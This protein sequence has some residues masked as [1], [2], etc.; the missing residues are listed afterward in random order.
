[1]KFLLKSLTIIMLCII[2]FTG[3][4]DSNGEGKNTVY[5][6]ENEHSEAEHSNVIKIS[7]ASMKEIGLYTETVTLKPFTGFIKIPAKVI[8]NQ[9]NEAQVGSLVQ[10]RVHKVFVKAGDYV[11]AGQQ[12]MQVEGLEIGVIKAGYLSAKA[13]FEFQK[14]NYNRQKTLI[15]QNIGSQKSLLEAKAEFEKSLAEY[16]AEDKKIHSVGLT[17]EDINIGEHDAQH[18]SGTLSVKSPISGIVVERNVV[19]GQLVDGTT[20]AFRIVNINSVWIDGQ[21]YEKDISKL[22]TKTNVVFTS[23]SYDEEKFTGRID[24]IGQIIDEKS[25]TIS[26]RA[27]FNNPNGKLKP[28]S[29]G[30]MHLQTGSNSMAILIPAESIINNE[31]EN[32]VFVQNQDSSFEKRV[33]IVGATQNEL[34]EIKKGLKEKEKVVVKGAF[35]LKS[36]LLKEELQGDEH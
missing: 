19:I 2:L 24:Y 9:D 20:T 15:G 5:S 6:E 30:E 4:G 13:N 7:E 32:Y 1:M 16:E 10:G 14:A 21:I 17:D 18:T 12:L 3:C 27:A 35:S 26:V 8:V 25:R 23:T 22:N 33:V 29:Y 31:N 36:E 28:Q 11:K 34:V